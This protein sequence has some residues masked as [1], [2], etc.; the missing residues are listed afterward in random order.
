MKA[1]FSATSP[2]DV[3][4]HSGVSPDLSSLDRSLVTGVAWTAIMRWGSQVISWVSTLY[5]AR[6]LVPGDYGL[7]AM[8]S[9]PIGLAR[10]VEDLGLDAI[11]VQD[12]TLTRVQLARLAGAAILLGLFLTSLFVILSIPIAGYF[13]EPAV[14]ALIC[15]LSLTLLVDAFQ[16]LPRALLQ[17]DLQF[18]RLAWLYGLQAL[19]GAAVAAICAAGGLGYWSLVIST[20]SGNIFLAMAMCWSRPYLPAWPREPGL[21][22]RSFLSG[23]HMI[24][25]RAGWYAYSNADSM[26]IGRFLGK[27]ALGMFG[28]AMTFAILPLQEVTTQ[29]SKVT[30]GIFSSVQSDL[31]KLR[32]YFLILTEAISY[33]TFPMS[34]GLALTADDLVLFALGEKWTAV[35]LP[36]QILCL[37]VALNTGQVLLAHVLMWTGRFRATMWLTLFA[38]LVLPLSFYLGLPYGIPGVAWGWVVGFPLSVIP[39]FVLVFKILD[40]KWSAYA[41]TLRPAVLACAGMVL[42]VLFVRQVMPETWPSAIR[43]ALQVTLGALTYTAIM[44]TVFRSRVMGLY[45]IIQGSLKSQ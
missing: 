29:V 35:I 8:A 26:L 18:R 13:N 17:R 20:L 9:I 37:Y 4:P 21:L 15:V 22:A 43:L 23:W 44:L 24:V 42:L 40:I 11:I 38:L 6:I 39:A 33:L 41:E 28:F 19:I 1:D 32:R 30:P 45:R 10:L 7:V 31:V 36:L 27:E 34:C 12:R 3:A 16:V 25:S 2:V 5:V 14:T